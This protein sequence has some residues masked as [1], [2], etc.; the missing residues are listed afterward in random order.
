M[1]T[2]TYTAGQI[3]REGL[4]DGLYYMAWPSASIFSQTENCLQPATRVTKRTAAGRR[5]LSKFFDKKTRSFTSFKEVEILSQLYG[6]QSSQALVKTCLVPPRLLGLGMRQTSSSQFLPESCCSSPRSDDAESSCCNSLHHFTG[7]L[8]AG[9]L[10]SGSTGEHVLLNSLGTSERHDTAED[11]E[12]SLTITQP[13]TLY[14]KN[15]AFEADSNPSNAFVDEISQGLLALM[16][17]ERAAAFKTSCVG[18]Q[19]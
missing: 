3:L 2:D 13:S 10:P 14:P 8:P 19:E 6:K 4:N 7:H 17:E 5:G 16:S 18:I 12:N 15:Q 1:A 9:P 11:S